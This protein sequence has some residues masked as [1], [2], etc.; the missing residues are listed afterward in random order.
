MPDLGQRQTE[1]GLGACARDARFHKRKRLA[2]QAGITA[3]RGVGRD[4][5]KLRGRGV[6]GL[7]D[8]SGGW[9]RRRRVVLPR[10]AASLP[11]TYDGLTATG[12]VNLAA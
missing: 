3:A 1:R 7:M 2:E 8:A 12:V 9:R 4:A 11:P 10:L 6:H 5:C